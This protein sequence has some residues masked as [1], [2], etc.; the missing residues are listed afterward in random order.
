MRRIFWDLVGR[1]SEASR[2]SIVTFWCSAHLGPALGGEIGAALQR[3]LAC[4][5]GTMGKRMRFG[6]SRRWAVGFDGFVST[7]M[8]PGRN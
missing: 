5:A 4:R 6:Y 3:W 8:M 2:V 7:C 1:D